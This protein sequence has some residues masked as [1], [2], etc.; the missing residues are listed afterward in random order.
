M[1]EKTLSRRS[2]LAGAAVA[3]AGVL[4]HNLPIEAQQ[5][6][7]PAAPADVYYEN[8]TA[9]WDAIGRPLLAGDPGYAAP[10][11]DRD[12][13]GVACETDPR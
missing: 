8:C 1:D 6:P 11:L 5:T 4:L 7:A 3:G 13:D 10:R 2:L 12:S 9:V